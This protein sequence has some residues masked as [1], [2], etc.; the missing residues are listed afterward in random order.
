MSDSFDKLVTLLKEL[1]RL[2][3]PDLDFG[4]HRIMNVKRAEITRFLEE[5]LLPQVQEAFA[6]HR[7][8]DTTKLETELAELIAAVQKAGVDPD[9]APS[10]KANAGLSKM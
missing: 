2:D 4:I 9:D 6:E 8:Q 3:Q 1:F 5:E 7:S 10:T